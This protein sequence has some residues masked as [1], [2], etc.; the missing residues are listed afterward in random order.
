MT[1]GFLCLLLAASAAAQVNSAIGGTVEDASK[2]L[3]P[4]VSV[5]ALNTQTGVSTKTVSNE[6][7][8]YNFPVLVPGRYDVRADL[9]GFRAKSFSGVELGAGVAVRLNFVLEVGT[10]STSV[11]VTVASDSLLASSSA[12]VGEV[13]SSTRVTNLPI[14]GNDVLDLVRIMPGYRES[15][16]GAAFDTF[17]GTSAA[18]V[19]TTRDGVSV[20]DGRFNNGV[21]STTTINPDLVGEIRLILTPVDAELGR[22]NAQVQIQTRSGTNRYT[23]TAA[24]YVRNTALNPNSW[25]NNRTGTAPNWFN[26][27]EYSVSYGGPII[28]NKTFF[29]ALWDQN[30]HRE[31][32]SV[33]GSVLTDTARLG[34][35]RYWDGWN[36]STYDRAMTTTPSTSTTRTAPAADIN[37]NP[38]APT[39]NAN[40]TPYSGAGLMCY[41][42][43]G[44]QRLDASGKMVPFTS[45]DCPGGT[46]L[47]P[48]AGTAAWDPLRP[49]VDSTGY[50]YSALLK[51]MP[52]ANYFGIP[53]GALTPDGLNTAS[54]RW[55]RGTGGNA[56]A[57]TTQGTG[58]SWAR[59]QINVK[60]DHNFN[61]NHKL[62]GSYTL[63]RNFAEAGLTNWPNGYNGDIIRNPHVLATNFT[64]TLGSNL[65]NEA[66]VGL[67]YNNTEGRM[68]FEGSN[69][70]KVQDIL[71]MVTGGA[72]PGYTR[73]TGAIYP[74]VF[75]AGVPGTSSYNFSGASSLFNMDGS[76]NGNRSIL[77]NYADTLSWTRGKHAFKFGTEIRPTT[78]R[79]FTNVP[80]FSMPRVNGGSGPNLSPLASGGTAALPAGA[81]VTVRN[82]AA[83]LA[84]TLAGSV[85]SVDMVYWMDS[86]KDVQEKKWHSIVTAKDYYRTIII[87]EASGFVKD[88][89]KLSRNFTLNLGV[90][91][92]Y[93]GSPYIQ[94]GF[95]TTPL[96]QGLGLFGIGRSTTAGL[97]D[98]WLLP[99]TNPVYLS[100]Y[101]TTAT[102]AN[103]LQCTTGAAQANLPSSSC[104]PNFMTA[105]EFI[106][107]NSP[108]PKKSAIRN[109]WN[110]FGPAIGFAWQV[111]WFGEGKTSIRGGY[112]LTYGAAGRNTSTI[113]G[114][115]GAVLGSSPGA[116]SNVTGQAQLAAQFPGETL[117]IKDI[118]RIVPLL[119]T[120]PAVPGGT[121]PIY[122]RS[123]T[124]YAYGADY[125][126]PYTE[127]FTLSVTNNVRRNMTVDI[128]YIGTQSKKQDADINLNLANVYNN[129]ELYNALDQARQGGNPLLL[130]QML[131][132][133][134]LNSGVSGY[135]TIGTVVNGVYQTGAMHL[136]RSSTFNTNLINGNYLAIANSLATSTTGVGYI[137]TTALPSTPSG[138]LLRNGCDR[139]A[140]TGSATFGTGSTAIQLRCFPE[141]YLFP[142]PQLSVANYRTNAASS[143]YHSMQAQFT[144]RPTQGF[145]VQ[146]T[147]TWSKSLGTAGSGNA[148]PLNR[149]ADYTKPFSSLT[150]DLRTNGT[151]ELPFGPNKLLFGNASG[152]IAR[153]IERWQTS[154]IMNLSSGR[155]ESISA[156][157]LNYAATS[158]PDVVGPWDIR[159][160]AVQWDGSKNQGFYFGNPSELVVVPDPQCALSGS[161]SDPLN[162]S[163][164]PSSFALNTVTCGLNAIARIV[165][166]GT[167]GA[168]TLA[169]GRIVQYALVNPKPG[170]QGTLG[171]ATIESPG[172][173]R[174][175]ANLTKS[176]RI[177]ESKSM[178]IRIDATNVL[179]HPTVG[180]P[181][182]SINSANFG[183]FTAGKTGNREFQGTLRLTF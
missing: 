66:K 101:G 180:S 82:N 5:T 128:R 50:V 44:T 28:K 42:V 18:T 68:A 79:G 94:E 77:Y 83:N 31:R 178:Q 64:S 56:G 167:A 102:A 10:V 1:A 174:F 90:R 93:Y 149:R 127:N 170:K 146:T 63:E 134:N 111:P 21:Y 75:R 153:A 87:N 22:G 121:L 98:G 36:P 3:I 103:A 156:G 119:P 35:F 48:P 59:K 145:N 139:I 17:A 16:Q 49:A 160:G 177:S 8:V 72:D 173:I 181:T 20:T 120:N 74:A 164:T 135:G 95:T 108:N 51:N 179:N 61:S 118:P 15:P 45:A 91:W 183:L 88:D 133:L 37:G 152:W 19:N 130:T 46:I 165:P 176:F 115:T 158:V 6:S 117:F 100:G 81:L 84:Y 166:A 148:D 132:G 155:P 11:D 80:Q 171:Q 154:I 105:L 73:D 169:D 62:S 2:A 27:H 39:L 141:N 131:A 140:S 67:R 122:A 38:L 41:S 116:L 92:E 76:H 112:Q 52:K 109:D 65:I 7:G 33:D 144:L 97:F 124:V 163:T 58:D 107:P 57:L 70:D 60:I 32:S 136:R 4:G 85:D 99:S 157:T 24:W 26:N 151:I 113:G 12:S 175:D 182:Y 86:F 110:N 138:R 54:V 47:T 125:A 150:H 71:K 96:D 25:A 78:S 147:Y 143:N 89:W 161:V 137:S 55:L 69:A 23:G 106:G 129:P 172:V 34:I 13:L 43:F 114:G 9:P 104:N 14:V 30:I 126:T 168:V 162:T 29:Y 142:N 53:S 159:S 123:A 40:G